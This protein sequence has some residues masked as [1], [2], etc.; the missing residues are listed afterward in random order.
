M[1]DL[2]ERIKAAVEPYRFNVEPQRDVGPELPRQHRRRAV[3]IVG[4]AAAVVVGALVVALVVPILAPVGPDPAAA[5]LLHRFERIAQNADP[6]PSPG[7]GQY[8]YSQTRL[9]Q[10]NLF[11]SADGAYRF[12]YSIAATEQRWLGVDASGRVITTTGDHPE[13]ATS[14]DRATYEAYLAAGGKAPE[15]WGKSYTDVYGPG[16]LGFRDTSGLPADPAELGRLIEDRQI[17]DGPNGDWESFVLATDLIRDSYARPELR[18][19][20]YAYMAGLSGIEVAGTVKDGIGRDGVALV[21]THDG[22]RN[23]VIFDRKSGAILGERYVVLEPNQEA[24]DNP[25]PTEVAYALAGQPMFV[26]TYVRFGEVVNSA[27]EHP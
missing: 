9:M 21:S 26:S 4:I 14:Q 17:V 19:A 18:A 20:L 8:V 15:D 5:A 10:S 1:N 27:H 22:V 11:I 23:E 24:Y 7:P 3:T 2:E 13:F 12:I 6:E 16:E 25:G